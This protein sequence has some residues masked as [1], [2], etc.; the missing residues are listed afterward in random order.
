MFFASVLS[1]CYKCRSGVATGPTCC[2][3]LLQLL[4]RRACAWEAE[5]DGGRGMSGPGRVKRE[6]LRRRACM[7]CGKHRG[8]EAWVRGLWCMRAWEAEGARV[9]E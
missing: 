5:E 4:G 7:G 1:G 3:R 2:N 8:M 9:S 6:L